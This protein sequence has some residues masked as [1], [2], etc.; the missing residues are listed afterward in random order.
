V[1][2]A[3]SGTVGVTGTVD[4]DG[5]FKDVIVYEYGK[6]LDAEAI[7]CASK[8][9]F[10]PAELHGKPVRIHMQMELMFQVM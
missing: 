2:K 6:D 1:A 7:A 3:L 8:S 10:R 4:V 5:D 9:R